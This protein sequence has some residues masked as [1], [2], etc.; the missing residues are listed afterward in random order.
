VGNDLPAVSGT[1]EID[2]LEPV[3]GEIEAR[4]SGPRFPRP[5]LQYYTGPR[6][7][8]TLEPGEPTRRR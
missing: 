7:I 4:P 8:I 6:R 1:I 3:S 2:A 5:R